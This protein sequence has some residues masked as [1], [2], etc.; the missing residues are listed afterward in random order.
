MSLFLKFFAALFIFCGL[1]FSARINL[2]TTPSFIQEKEKVSSHHKP[3]KLILGVSTGHSG[4]TTAQHT[5]ARPGCFSRVESKFEGTIAYYETTWNY[6]S[7]H[8]TCQLVNST[9]IPHLYRLAGSNGVLLDVG[10]YHNRGVVLECLVDLLHVEAAFVR[11]RRNRYDIATS[12]S[13]HYYTPCLN[14]M[15]TNEPHPTASLCP[16]SEERK[17]AGPV[18]LNVDD[19]TWDSVFTPFQRFLWYADEIEEKWNDLITRC[20]GRTNHP[21]FYEVTWSTSS[22]LQQGLYTIRARLGCNDTDVSE[23]NKDTP[24]VA[25]TKGRQN[26]SDLIRQD[27][28]YRRWIKF[29]FEHYNRLFRRY[30]QNVASSDCKDTRDELVAAIQMYSDNQEVNLNAWILPDK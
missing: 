4:S 9:L 7:F 3:P 25:H 29:D 22:E 1:L 18:Y 28:E 2:V 21:Q 15:S 14:E 8:H 5:L 6:T 24:H 19:S 10:H 23:I 11:I 17:T 12:F 26:C 16:H 20:R 27:L 30:P 13:S